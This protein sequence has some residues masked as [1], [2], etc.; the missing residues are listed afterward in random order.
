MSFEVM[1]QNRWNFSGALSRPLLTMGERLQ[2][3]SN[4]F[5][6]IGGFF[7]KKSCFILLAAVL[8]G[9][10][11]VSCAKKQVRSEKK[12]AV[13]LFKE[14]RFGEAIPMFTSTL[15]KTQDPAEQASAY[16]F[17]GACYR[18]TGKFQDAYADF[19]AAKTLSCWA[20]ENDKKRTQRSQLETPINVLCYELAPKNLNSL[21]TQI[22]AGE[23]KAARES[24]RKALDVK[25]FAD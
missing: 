6:N 2:P 4:H 9:M 3:A 20:T 14:K 13:Q 19:F 7:M 18:E 12:E 25:Y 17:R 8:C 21:S 22:S 23:K 5:Y 10:L 24:V 11:L 1:L 15:G 16:A